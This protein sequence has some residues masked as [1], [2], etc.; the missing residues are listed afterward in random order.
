MIQHLI[1][2][3][4]DLSP[5]FCYYSNP[6]K[7]SKIIS[8]SELEKAADFCSKNGLYV[9]IVYGHQPLPKEYSQLLNKLPHSKIG[10]WNANKSDNNSLTVINLEDLTHLRQQKKI[11]K[12]V[13]IKIPLNKIENIRNYVGAIVGRCNR[14]NVIIEGLEYVENRHY[15]IVRNEINSLRDELIKAIT[16]KQTEV[17]FITDLW[18]LSNMNNCNA[19]IN[20]ITLAPNGKFYICPGFYYSNERDSIGDVN[21]G[22]DIINRQLLEISHAPICKNCDVYH[23]KRCVY[24]NKSTTLEINTPSIQQCKISHIERNFSKEILEEVSK[25]STKFNNIRRIESIAYEDP[26][27]VLVNNN[28]H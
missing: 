12:N 11:A 8:I 20:H 4:D 26:F 21:N 16:N 14:L 24:L 22:I 23:C 2:L 15:E 18:L 6:S 7:S 28:N 10:P 19:G 13:A 25:V 27:E 9:S 3:L 5:S 17:N 1:I